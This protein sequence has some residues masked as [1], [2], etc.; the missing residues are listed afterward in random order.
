LILVNCF[1]GS[2]LPPLKAGLLVVSIG[3]SAIKFSPSHDVE[4]Q[5]QQKTLATHNGDTA[6]I[7]QRYNND[8][9]K[10]NAL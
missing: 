3:L 5:K 10:R 8:K 9:T 6:A 7:Q 4:L 2:L 1:E